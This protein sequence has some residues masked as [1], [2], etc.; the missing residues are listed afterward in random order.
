MTDTTQ[1]LIRNLAQEAA[2]V[3]PVCYKRT[4]LEW[5]AMVVFNIIL[6]SQFYGLR[7][8]MHLKMADPL[9]ITELGL[10]ALLIVLM[11]CIASASAFP[12]RARNRFLL[13]V[14]GISFAAYTAVLAYVALANVTSL[15]A[16]LQ[17]LHMGWHC[18]GCIASYAILP[19]L[20]V[21]W[22]LRKLASTQP[23]FTGF[24]VLM[25]AGLTGTLGVR[26]VMPES[27]SPELLLFHYFPLLLLCLLGLALGKKL[28]RW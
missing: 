12:G 15:D 22:R 24:C 23:V 20:Y 19:A 1:D 25:L 14:M 21:S 17:D 2:P 3:K 7:P 13:S 10:N 26:L 27:N 5:I 8:D 6:V 9:Y 18:T 28:F 11:G 4:C 16:A